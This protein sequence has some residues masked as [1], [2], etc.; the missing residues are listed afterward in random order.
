MMKP[1]QKPKLAFW[2]GVRNFAPITLGAIPFGLVYGVAAAEIGITPIEGIGMSIIMLAGAAQLVTIELLKT[3]AAA[4]VIILSALIVNLRFIIYSASLAP[5]FK[6]FSMRWK[7]LDGYLLTDQPYALS[8]SYF[9]EH[10]DAPHKHWYH[11][12][13]GLSLWLIWVASSAVGL[14][15]GS[16]I[17]QSWSLGFVI[18]L[19]FLALVVPAIR[20][21]SYLIAALVSGTIAVV[22]HP[23]PNNLGLPIAIICGIVTGV[24]LEKFE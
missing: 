14:L 16:F 1:Y 23:L 4:W 9:N 12:G 11:F 20:G 18:P 6:S 21:R 10:P 17:P 8:I 7:L 2:A 13:H 24:I 15:V 3:D 19:M 5:H 22:A